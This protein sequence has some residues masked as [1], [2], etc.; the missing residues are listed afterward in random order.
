[1]EFLLREV[2]NDQGQVVY[3]DSEL[4]ADV[5]TLGSSGDQLIQLRG[6][7]I[8]S[9]HAVLKIIDGQLNV[10]GVDKNA[11]VVNG[12]VCKSSV[13]VEGD[14]LCLASHTITI[15][16][17]PAGF[18]AACELSIDKELQDQALE[19]AYKTSLAD[20]ALG[21]RFPAYLLSLLVI[22]TVL[23]RPISAY[24]L[25]D[26]PVDPSSGLVE[27]DKQ[28]GAD[29]LWSSGPLLPAHQL[30]VGDDC[31]ACHKV[32]FQTVQDEA[33]AACHSSVADHF[34]YDK[35]HGGALGELHIDL[36]VTECQ[37]CH[38]EHNEPAAMVVS[39]DSLCVDCHEAPLT[40]SESSAGTSVVTG[41]TKKTHSPFKVNYLLPKVVQKGTGIGVEWYNRFYE[42]DSGQKEISNLKFPHDAHLDP[43]KV[44]TA[45]TGEGMVC[46]DCHSLK[47]DNEHFEDINMEQH[48]SACHDLSFDVA[49][50]DRVLPHGD[51][52]TVVQTI[53]EH[54]VRVYTDPNYKPL[55]SDRKRRR[56][57]QSGGVERCEDKPFDCGMKRAT[58]EAG[59]QFTQRGCITCHEVSDN[60]SDDIYA[61]WTVLPVKINHDWY[62]R[63]LFDHSSHLTQ[64][65]QSENEVCS[66]C[67]EATQ[68][69]TSHDVLIPG[70][71]NCLSC[72]GDVS[73]EDKVMVNCIA[74]HA[75]HP[76]TPFE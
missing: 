64:R 25:R 23:V 12:D 65:S 70:I 59:I 31:S 76:N 16:R 9:R 7:N 55:G 38:K 28:G 44:Q 10:Q 2:S 60:N 43:E 66:S 61:R 46:S 34:Q 32:P 58:I 48:C 22:A 74:C 72:H 50:P 13:L 54:F 36:G 21:K 15:S 37:S 71:D 19:S 26:N 24:L 1:M 33:C 57:G 41:F 62:S 4:A 53:E 3:K 63:A 73:V 35:A 6:G 47:S 29:K 27:Y 20:T 8:Q 68:S 14:E 75:F 39:A 69:S 17:P 56:P 49:D 45:G 5:I 51:P 42:A 40:L 18:D 11:V 30:E 52:R 67:H